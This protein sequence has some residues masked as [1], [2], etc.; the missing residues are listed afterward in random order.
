[1]LRLDMQAPQISDAD[2]AESVFLQADYSG[3]KQVQRELQAALD[4]LRST[5][6]QRLVRYIT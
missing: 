3:M 6:C 4:E 1:M 2:G 5:H